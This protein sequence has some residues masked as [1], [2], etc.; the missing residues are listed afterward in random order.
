MV[1]VELQ[2]IYFDCKDWKNLI[3]NAVSIQTFFN[4]VR[5]KFCI[6]L[7][8]DVLNIHGIPLRQSSRI[9]LFLRTQTY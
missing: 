4:T 3:P 5:P 2:K 6:L 1:F 8:C 7:I 9:S